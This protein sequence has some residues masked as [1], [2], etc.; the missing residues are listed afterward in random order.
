MWLLLVNLRLGFSTTDLF[1]RIVAVV[2][3]VSSEIEV[4]EAQLP[5][6]MVIS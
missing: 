5:V 1:G 2:L 6:V 3:M 4:C